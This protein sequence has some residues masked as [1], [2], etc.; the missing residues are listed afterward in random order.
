MPAENIEGYP[1]SGMQYAACWAA[2]IN[3][4][5]HN[6][7]WLISP[8]LSGKAQSISFFAKELTPYYGAEKFQVLYSTSGN[9]TKDF[10][11]IKEFEVTNYLDWQ[12]YNVEL[13]EGALYFA[14]R[15]VTRD[16][17]LFMIDDI[18]FE[19]GSCKDIVAYRIYRDRNLIAEVP[20]NQLVYEDKS[21]NSK[22]EYNVTALYATGLESAFSNKVSSSSGIGGIEIER[23]QAPYNVYSIDGRMIL[24]NAESLDGL[25]PG[26]Y[27]VNG[28]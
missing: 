4:V 2:D 21:G 1:H 5:A 26:I 7:D 17:H 15:V 8:I 18:T 14:I 19:A 28:K 6:D 9:D 24:K 22:N 10:S 25:N 13:P 11:L 20:D 16:G 12:R 3:Q 23:P 27:I